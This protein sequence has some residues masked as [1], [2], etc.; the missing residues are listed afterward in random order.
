ML[1]N[2]TTA[3]F[4]LFNL[5]CYTQTNW[6]IEDLHVTTFRNGDRLLEA[7]TESNWKFCNENQLPAY[8]LLGETPEDGVLYNFYA[9]HDTRQLA[10]EGYRIPELEDVKTLPTEQ[11]YQSTNGGWK[12]NTGTG[13]F[14]ANASGYMPHDIESFEVLS[15]G[16]FAYY[17]TNTNGKTFHSMSFV[18]VDGEK[19]YSIQELRREGFCAV[20]C[21]KKNDESAAFTMSE[22][23]IAKKEKF[24]KLNRRKEIDKEL[25]NLN[26]D[27][28]TKEQELREINKRT[29]D[30]EREINEINARKIELQNE[31]KKNNL[32]LSSPGAERTVNV[33]NIPSVS[34]GNQ[35]WMTEN[36]NVDKFRN[37]DPIPEAKT[38][39]EWKKAGANG[40]PAWC[41][42]D[43][44]PA[45]GEKYGKLYNWYA[46][47][48]PRGLAP[49]GWKI[50]SDDEWSRLVNNLGG[51]KVA[52]PKMKS[53][54]G[55]VENG[56]DTNESEFSG[57]PGGERGLYGAFD[58]IGDSG[59]WWS[60]TEGS[61]YYAWSRYL[62]FNSGSA[63]RYNDGKQDG[64][65]VRCLR[66]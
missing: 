21:V 6:S 41:Y 56:K 63:G 14:N 7:N 51:Q 11:Y 38:A 2:I 31:L 17:W 10:P 16:V 35:I 26:V 12:T 4:C 25:T 8:L 49:E 34:I 61:T 60:S 18:I 29:S 50:P 58:G 39:E 54:S 28:E 33:K 62:G 19:G 3:I 57:L 23:Q 66:D 32:T 59:S 36:L 22:G 27:L 55:W 30:L 15:Q 64:F 52:G 44:D 47:N 46:V 37:G 48:D 5:I 65:S 42:Y 1:K 9:I 43:N 53:T 40:E 45:N 13:Y 20:R 24:V